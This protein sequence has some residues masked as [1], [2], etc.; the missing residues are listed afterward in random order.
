[1][2]GVDGDQFDADE[3]VG[4]TPAG[5]IFERRTGRELGPDAAGAV[6]SLGFPS[7]VRE[8]DA[9]PYDVEL[10]AVADELARNDIGRGVIANADG[11]DGPG[12]EFRHREA[13]L[14]LVDGNGVV[15][16]GQVASDL[17]VAD[18]AAPFGVR[19][20]P[21]RVLDAFGRMWPEDE[22][23]G[24][25]LV[26]ASDLARLRRYE[27]VTDP[28]QFDDLR[29]TALEDADDLFGRLLAEV[30]PET[31]GVLVV[32]PTE[33]RRKLTV[34]ALKTPGSLPGYVKSASSQHDGVAIAI[35]V[36]PTIL[37]QFGI[38]F[39]ERM[40]GRPYEI[41]PSDASLAARTDRFIEEATGS[42]RRAE[43]LAP[44]SAI[45]VALLA[46]VSAGTVAIVAFGGEG[47]R[48]HRRRAVAW[49]ALFALATL[50]STL[51]VQLVP[52][53]IA[54]FVPYLAAVAGTAAVI[55]TAAWFLPR[56][57][58]PM[59]GMLAFMLGL[60][61]VDAMTGSHMHY[62]AVFGYSPTANSRLYGISNYSFGV[63]MTSSILLATFIVVF[64][65]TRFAFPIAL[66]LLGFVLVV[67]GLPAWGSDVGGVL[68]AVP[69]FLLFTFLVRKRR[70]RT[71]TIVL[72]V[73]ATAL[74]IAVFAGVDLLRPENERAHLGRLVERVNDDGLSPLYAIVERKFVAAIRESTRSVWTLAIPIG[75]ALIVALDRVGKRPLQIL[76]ERISLLGAALTTIYVGAFLGSALNDSGAIV[77][78]IMFFTLAGALAYASLEAT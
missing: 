29:T 32:G 20:D 55:A 8:N 4:A 36:G 42:A 56:P 22:A 65:R 31:D 66:A 21:D 19:T 37:D 69:T 6:V 70:V 41:V 11:V 50:P 40:E 7:L 76:R 48:A 30:D 9:L 39:T 74:A 71:R 26:E 72:A 15:P 52:G 47:V 24:V 35:D 1:M 49:A 12:L 5:E 75:I 54:G 43:R 58:G 57:Y 73:V 2:V 27:R 78:G 16:D 17:L 23:Q 45:L 18:A 38:D 77:G 3:L 53:G 33:G 61:L 46:L 28:V 68:A 63:V 51:L 13:A 14:A 62:N 59:I 10:G 34:T 44:M 25:V 67:E 60:V 64:A